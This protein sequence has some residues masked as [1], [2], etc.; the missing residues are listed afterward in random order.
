MW[1]AEIKVGIEYAFR[2]PP[3]PGVPL[4]RVRVLQHVRGNKWK[5]EWVDPNP[6]LADYVESKNLVVAWKDR[7][8]FLR[9]EEHEQRLREDADRHR[10]RRESPVERALSVVFE[11]VKDEVTFHRG[12]LT[13]GAGRPQAREGARRQEPP[14]QLR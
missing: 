14:A 3:K 9:D 7:R 8:A 2:E 11:S 4:Q 10:G 5:A 12:V 13:G 1:R 6:G